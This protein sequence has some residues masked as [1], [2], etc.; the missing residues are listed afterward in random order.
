M[1]FVQ[2]N[3]MYVM[4]ALVSGGM[5]LWQTV[6]S[7]GGNR[8]SPLQATLMLNRE[9]ALVIDVRETGEWASGHIPNARH[10]ALGQLEKRLNELEKFKDKPLIVNCQSGNRSSAA[11]STLKKHG[12]EKVFNLNGGIGAWREAGLPVTTK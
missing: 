7:S 3:L 9:D 5:L 1:E 12:F 4:L 8:I 6:S 11:C 2:N 10:I